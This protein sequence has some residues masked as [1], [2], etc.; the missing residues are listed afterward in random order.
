LNAKSLVRFSAP[1][2][3]VS[4]VGV[5]AACGGSVDSETCA[6][7][8]VGNSRAD[9][10]STLGSPTSVTK[11]GNGAFAT[12]RYESEKDGVTQCCFVRFGSEADTALALT[13][14]TFDNKCAAAAAA[15][16]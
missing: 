6:S 2:L 12:A 15:T 4:L 11:G 16:E 1:F 3:L 7:I 14:A 9:V 8:K 10:D 13:G 5:L